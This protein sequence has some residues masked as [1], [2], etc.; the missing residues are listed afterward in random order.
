ME[1]DE[2]TMC[3]SYSSQ[4]VKDIKVSGVGSIV[5][6]SREHKT[7]GNVLRLGFP[8][9]AVMTSKPPSTTSLALVKFGKGMKPASKQ[10][11]DV[12]L[13]LKP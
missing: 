5:A 7:R 10:K 9:A 2:F 1:D 4:Q 8:P 6:V 3:A 12:V 13:I 11:E